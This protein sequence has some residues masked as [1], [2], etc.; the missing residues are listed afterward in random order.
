MMADIISTD[1]SSQTLPDMTTE[2]LDK[3]IQSPTD[4]PPQHRILQR[5]QTQE[6]VAT[7]KSSIFDDDLFAENLLE[8]FEKPEFNLEELLSQLGDPTNE[9]PQDIHLVGEC[10]IHFEDVVLAPTICCQFPVCDTCIATYVQLQVSEHTLRVGPR[11][12]SFFVFCSLNKKPCHFKFITYLVS[13]LLKNLLIHFKSGGSFT[14]SV[15]PF[16]IHSSRVLFKVVVRRPV[17]VR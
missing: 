2:G 3:D 14:V 13:F 15:S 8:L 5:Q 7:L 12:F 10:Q 17:Q 11:L 16:A 6:A 9:P 4:I 1:I